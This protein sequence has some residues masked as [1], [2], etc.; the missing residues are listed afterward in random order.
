MSIFT[1][2]FVQLCVKKKISQPISILS[3]FWL[4][5]LSQFQLQINEKT[6]NTH[7]DTN[8]DMYKLFC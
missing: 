2:L 6:H 7:S 1:I 8:T 3:H 4:Q 5:Y